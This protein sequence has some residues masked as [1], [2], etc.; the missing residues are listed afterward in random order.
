MLE[1]DAHLNDGEGG[2]FVDPIPEFKLQGYSVKNKIEFY[3]KDYGR[4]YAT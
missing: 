1:E 4:Q 2:S 3:N